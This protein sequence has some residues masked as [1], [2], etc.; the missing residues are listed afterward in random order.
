MKR[1]RIYKSWQ[2][3]VV[4][5]LLDAENDNRFAFLTRF[6]SGAGGWKVGVEVS[7]RTRIEAGAEVEIEV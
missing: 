7:L 5:E 4:K 2:L 6:D 3:H 1:L